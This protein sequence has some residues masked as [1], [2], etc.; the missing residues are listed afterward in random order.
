[1]IREADIEMKKELNR[2]KIEE[3]KS[4]MW[5]GFL[6][7]FI[8]GLAVDQ[9][10]DIIGYFKGTVTGDDI[11]ITIVITAILCLI[12]LGAYAYSFLKNVVD[13]FDSLKKEKPEDVPKS[14]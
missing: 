9:A 5:S 7:A 1:M 4:L 11:W 3:L 10:T 2:Q 14:T 12:C 13:L 8:V 6:L